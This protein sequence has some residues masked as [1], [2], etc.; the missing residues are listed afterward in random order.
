MLSGLARIANRATSPHLSHCIVWRCP[1]SDR[2]VETS[3]SEKVKLDATMIAIR[4]VA[5]SRTASTAAPNEPFDSD[6]P[7]AHNGS[8]SAV[9]N[10]RR[11]R[12]HTK[13][14]GYALAG[15]N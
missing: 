3:S 6:T 9:A 15:R 7:M 13:C 2:L 10:G 11:F 4:L 5:N 8:T 12:M 14:D 1:G